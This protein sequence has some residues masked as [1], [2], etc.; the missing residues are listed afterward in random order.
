MIKIE[1]LNG[2]EDGKIYEFDKNEVFI[3]RKREINDIVMEYD[4][5]LS[6]EHARVFLE[7]NRIYLEDLGSTRGTFVNH[8]RNPIPGEKQIKI[9]DEIRVGRMVLRILKGR[10]N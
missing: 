6:R 9:G 3:G 8:N 2:P 10:E 1:V 5:L 4:R 7:Q